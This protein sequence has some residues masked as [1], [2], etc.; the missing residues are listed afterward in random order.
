MQKKLTRANRSDIF[1]MMAFDAKIV[2][3]AA[4]SDISAGHPIRTAVDEL[5]NG[6]VGVVQMRNVDVDGGV[7]WK[8]V[9]RVEPPPARRIDYLALGDIIFSTRGARNHAVALDHIPFPSVCSPHFF[10]IRVRCDA[11]DPHFLAWQI[12]QAPAQEYLQNAA[13]GSHVLN[14]RR[15]VIEQ[16]EIVLPPRVQQAAIVAFAEAARREKQAF[17]ALVASR[18][19]QMD[20]LAAGLHRSIKE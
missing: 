15:E 10:V 7:D 19:Q 12:N 5:P 13:T 6:D 1:R 11:L 14:I 20:M 18:Q 17:A 8:S 3:V 4:T 16:L 2:T 9:S